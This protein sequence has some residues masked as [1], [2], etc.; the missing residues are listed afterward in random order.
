MK[1]AIADGNPNY[2]KK[3]FIAGIG[4]KALFFGRPQD[5]FGLGMY[6]YGLSDELEDTINPS[7]QIGDESAIEAYYNWAV[8]PWLLLGPDIQYV[9]PARER[10]DKA[11]V[12][13]IRMQIRL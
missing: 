9:N 3:S 10:F 5:N 6:Y 2:V 4:G 13:A 8:A 1:A 7:A 12:A 11:L